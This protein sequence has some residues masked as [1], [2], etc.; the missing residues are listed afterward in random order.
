MFLHR[1]SANDSRFKTIDFRPGL[2]LLVADRQQGSTTGDSRNGTGKT[3]LAL[4]LRYMLGGNLAKQFKVPEL[5][6]WDFSLE[7]ELPAP[8]GSERVRV[9]R[10]IK[11]R[12]Q[13]EISGWS[14][15]GTNRRTIHV[16]EWRDLLGEHVFNLSAEASPSLTP[17]SLWARL[18][19][20]RFIGPTKV[21]D[22]DSEWL[23]GVRIG[24]L[25]GLDPDALQGGGDVLRMERQRKGL[26]EAIKEGALKSLTVDEPE[27]RQELAN[28]R[29]RRN[30]E[31]ERLAG[32]RVDEQYEEHQQRADDVTRRIQS[33]ND[34]ALS[35]QRRARE[36]RE[37]IEAE[38]VRRNANDVDRVRQL[39][40]EVSTLFPEQ[41]VRRYEEVAAFHQS[42]V[43]N[44]QLYLEGE[45]HAVQ[46]RLEEISTE[47]QRLDR[48][49]AA[50]MSILRETVAFATFTAA[51]QDVAALDARAAEIERQLESAAEINGIDDSIKTATAD[52]T[53]TLRTEL[54]ER[55][56][57][58]LDGPLALFGALG[59]EIYRERTASLR[60]SVNKKGAFTVEP[61]ISGDASDGIRAVETFLLDTV[62][63]TTAV[64]LVRAPGL[65]VHDSHLFDPIDARQGSSC[66]NIGARLADE[67]GYQYFVTMNSDY[68]ARIEAEGG[69]DSEPYALSTRLTDDR[70][71]GGLF[72]F[73]FS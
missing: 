35:L 22:T 56:P 6:N 44:R 63:I 13:V 31:V 3:S 33:L 62:L 40:G 58:L 45:D 17:G 11:P 7:L 54:A 46:M 25:L 2:N 52:A 21:L 36:L 37:A 39:F 50:T 70:D 19:R 64:S 48:E 26:R 14:V 18:I 66:L 41:V 59:A 20:D 68:L 9:T 5:E 1:L 28:I 32:F 38:G 65:L 67:Y 71:D 12:T 57:Y 15:L 34:E 29:R 24:Y 49:R 42:V 73:Q 60:Y 51:Q 69:F 4:L 23:T 43:R 8:G 10:P 27:L 55:E 30:V 53:R 61:R 47:R 72:G 16:S